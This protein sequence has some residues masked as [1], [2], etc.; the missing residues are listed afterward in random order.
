MDSTIYFEVFVLIDVCSAMYFA[1]TSS[2]T[3]PETATESFLQVQKLGQQMVRRTAFE[4]YP[5]LMAA[6]CVATLAGLSIRGMLEFLPW[7]RRIA[8]ATR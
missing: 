8:T 2:A 3:F 5:R 7:I 1:I 4:K 6:W